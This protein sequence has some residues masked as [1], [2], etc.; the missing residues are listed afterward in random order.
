LENAIVAVDG[1]V[2]SDGAVK[3]LGKRSATEIHAAFFAG[4]DGVRPG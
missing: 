2:R 4:G 3:L 1:Y